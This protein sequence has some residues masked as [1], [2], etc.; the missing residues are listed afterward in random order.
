MEKETERNEKGQPMAACVFVMSND[1][2]VLAV[3]RKD[4]PNDFGMP[5]G[6]VDKG[7]TPAEAAARE[8][9]EETGL[10]ASN[11]RQ[12]FQHYDGGHCTHT[13]C[14]DVGGQI[15]TDE[16]GIVRWVDPLILID[17]SRFVDYNRRL[18]AVLD[19]APCPECGSEPGCNI[20]CETC[21]APRTMRVALGEL[22]QMIRSFMK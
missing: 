21:M 19:L 11:L 17:Q 2:K 8:F 15:D 10:R 13:F 1:G 14:G 6:K 16:G 5:G 18:F 7:E 9:K 3:S 12:V 22:R 4:D 20:D